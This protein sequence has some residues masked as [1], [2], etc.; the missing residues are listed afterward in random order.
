MP[1][2]THFRLMVRLAVLVIPFADAEIVTA[3]FPAPDDV[4][5]VN[6]AVD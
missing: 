5:T 4:D 2:G 1:G 6:V 3:P